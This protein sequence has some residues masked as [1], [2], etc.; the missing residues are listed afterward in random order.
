MAV[1]QMTRLVIGDHLSGA[2][3]GGR[4]G[5]NLDQPFMDVFDLLVPEDRG[6]VVNGIVGQELVIV[7]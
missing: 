2:W 1:S 7:F 5:A 3:I 6:F 4:L